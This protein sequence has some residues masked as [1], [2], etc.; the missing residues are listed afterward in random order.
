MIV[1][2]DC[3]VFA[4]D[5]NGGSVRAIIACRSA[6][7]TDADKGGI[8]AAITVEPLTSTGADGRDGGA[9]II[10]R[11]PPSIGSVRERAACS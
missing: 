7:P 5:A 11:S 3:L 8:F 4:T 2:I 6:S 10:S 9:A 1:V